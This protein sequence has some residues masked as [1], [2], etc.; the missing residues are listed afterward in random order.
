MDKQHSDAMKTFLSL[1]IILLTGCTALPRYNYQSQSSSDPVIIFGDR[2]GESAISSPARSFSI[3]T[4]DAAANICTDFDFVGTTS[5]HW[6]R[7]NSSTIQIKAPVGRAVAIRGV[8][9]YSAT[10]VNTQAPVTTCEPPVL[11]FPPKAA[12]IYSVDVDTAHN[13]CS[14]SIVQKLPNGQQEKVEGLTVLPA[15]R[16]H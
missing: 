11:M 9:F 14:L 2:F 8:Y 1:L 4:K 6:M 5:D 3:N 15:C 13:N 10:A 16:D 7:L 12:A